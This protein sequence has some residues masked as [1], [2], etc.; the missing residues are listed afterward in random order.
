MRGSSTQSMLCEGVSPIREPFEIE[1][2]ECKPIV[3]ASKAMV[4][5]AADA[6]IGATQIPEYDEWSAVEDF[7]GVS[8]C[9]THHS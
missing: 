1:P 7:A 9:G 4:I 6:H 3:A 2:C 5:E 8:K